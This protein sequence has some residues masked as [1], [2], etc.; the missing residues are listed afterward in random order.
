[1][2][3]ALATAACR[4][5][6][7]HEDQVRHYNSVGQAREALRPHLLDQPGWE[8]LRDAARAWEDAR[9]AAYPLLSEAVEAIGTRSSPASPPPTSATAASTPRQPGKEARTHATPDPEPADER[10][11]YG[12]IRAGRDGKRLHVWLRA[13]A[14]GG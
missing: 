4:T 8:R 10:W 11:T 12:G 1:V 2:A 7:G 9:R 3:G 13:I 5:W 6:P 14:G